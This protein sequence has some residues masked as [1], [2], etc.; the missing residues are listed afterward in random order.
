[1]TLCCRFP[2]LWWWWWWWWWWCVYPRVYVYIRLYVMCTSACVYVYISVCVCVCLCVLIE[3]VWV[4]RAWVNV[5]L[6]L[7]RYKYGVRGNEEI[8][9]QRNHKK[10]SCRAVLFNVDGSG[11][12]PMVPSFTLWLSVSDGC[13]SVWWLC[14]SFTFSAG[15]ATVQPATQGARTVKYTRSTRKHS[16][17]CIHGARHT[18]HRLLS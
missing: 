6:C 14:F 3:L 5:F 10:G 12:H 17:L 18:T 13:C 15:D 8:Y 16:R 2:R 4:H 11:K 7:C 9:S 1:V